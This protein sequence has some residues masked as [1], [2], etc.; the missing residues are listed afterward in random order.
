MKRVDV[1]IIGAGPAGLAVAGV[2]GDAGLLTLVLD[3]Q[4]TPGGQIWRAADRVLADPRRAGRYAASFVHAAETLAAARKVA[5][6]KPLSDI[7]DISPERDILW[8]DRAAGRLVETRA[9][10]LIL[11]PG[12]ME[13]PVPLPGWTLPGV[14]GA[15][16]LQIA[17]KQATLVPDEP[18]VLAGQGPLLLLVTRQLQAA[19]ARIAAMLDFGSAMDVAHT[20][21]TLPKALLSDAKLVAE[22]VR[23]AASRALGSAK[24]YR[25]VRG[26]AAI[27]TDAVE[28]VRFEAG[29]RN[30]EVRASLLA[31]HD[32]VTPN[33]QLSRL[34]GLTHRFRETDAAF[35]PV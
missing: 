30:H 4:P 15:G 21:R 12:A 25:Q 1:A 32:G 33:I 9:R 7:I 11:A 29:G 2:T 35:A 14:M 20:M 23:L 28:A 16:A 19:G 31:L 27:G 34:L 24:V 6:L 17:M 22:G 3:E 13:R 8:L 18:I 10:A 26:I 5:T